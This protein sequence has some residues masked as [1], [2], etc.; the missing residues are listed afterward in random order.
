MKKTLR[1]LAVGSTA[2]ACVL[3]TGT[4]A[5]ANSGSG[6]KY[7]G[8]VNSVTVWRSGGNVYAQGKMTCDYAMMILR[9]DAALSSYKKGKLQD[10]NIHG[11]RGCNMAKSCKS[12]KIS[13]KAHKGWSYH[14]TNGGTT[15]VDEVWPKNTAAKVWYTYK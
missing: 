15:D 14:G 10:I 2:L 12:K 1:A 5:Q 6:K 9:P 4:G 8:C 11:L 7:K 3:V 13:L